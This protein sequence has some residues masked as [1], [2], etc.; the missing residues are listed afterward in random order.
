MDDMRNIDKFRGC[1]IGG[2]AGDALGYAVEFMDEK[3][4]ASKYGAD[5]ISEYE[6]ANGKALI[7]DDTQMTLFTANGLLYG[8]TRGR[9][10]GIMADYPTY[11]WTM[12][13]CWYRTQTE[14]YPIQN[15]R[16][17]YSWLLNVPE[18]FSQRAPGNTC[19]SALEEGSEHRSKNKSK[20]CGGVMRVAPVGLYF[21]GKNITYDDVDKIGAATASITHD[22]ELGYIPAATLVHIIRKIAEEP[23]CSLNEAIKGAIDNTARLYKDAEE[24]GYYTD[25]MNKAVELASSNIPDIDAIHQLG[26]GWV[27]EETLAI[28][29]F[30]ALRYD[31]DFD[32]AI[33]CAVNHNGDSDSTGAVTGNILG[34]FI[35]YEA[36]PQKYK[37]NLELL[38][39]ILSIADDLCNDCQMSEYDS[40]RDEIWVE[41]Y[42]KAS[43]KIT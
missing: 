29:V 24:I 43:Y 42:I 35:G 37:D 31:K 19:L 32:K 20:G 30:C 11:I 40:Y 17:L 2:A 1:L 7:S 18:L 34:A 4:I 33:R 13:K 5:G 8:T 36:I 38:N 23:G 12:Y 21:A 27:A 22:H 15:K 3:H 25:L 9:M 14:K 28:A 41:K 26:E 10:R 39:V 6:L 16:N